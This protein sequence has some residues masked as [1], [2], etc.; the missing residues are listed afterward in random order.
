MIKIQSVK[1]YA[2][3]YRL[4]INSES[5]I[6]V[7]KDDDYI[8]YTPNTIFSKSPPMTYIEYLKN[9]KILDRLEYIKTLMRSVNSINNFNL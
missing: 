4:R 7:F 1:E 2:H 8:D 6:D 9:M 5:Y 3:F